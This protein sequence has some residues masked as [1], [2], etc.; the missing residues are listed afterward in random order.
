MPAGSHRFRT[1]TRRLLDIVVNSLYSHPDVFLRELV[2]NASDALDRLR[3]EALTDPGLAAGGSEPGIL[4]RPDAASGTL[5]VSDNGIGMTA[6]ELSRNLGTIAGSGTGR[7]LQG[8]DPAS[9][10]ELIGRFGVG[11]YSAFMVAGRVEV[12]SRRAGSDEPAARWESDGRDS[13][14]VEEAER[15]VGGT[16]VILHLK[17]GMEEYLDPERLGGIIRAYSDYLPHPVMLAMPDGSGGRAL[18]SGTPLWLTPGKDVR[19]GGYDDFYRRLSGS[20]DAP[21]SHLSCHVE[22]A[23][24]FHALLFIPSKRPFEAL[25]PDW[26]PGIDLYSRRI[27]ILQACP[28]ILPNWLRFVGGVVESPDLPLNISREMLQQSPALR[29][30]GRALTRKV[31]DWLARLAAGD[32]DGYASF[33]GEFGDFLKEGLLADAENRDETAGLL[34]AW[35]ASNPDRPL[36]LKGLPSD[37]P[38]GGNLY[39]VSGPD[40]K[41]LAA[42]PHLE[43]ARSAGAEVLLFDGPLDELIAP[44]LSSSLGR[45]LIALDREEADADLSDEE[46][47]RREE[48]SARLSGLL[49]FMKDVLGGAVGDVRVST[50]LDRSPCVVVPGMNDPGGAFRGMM[51]AMRREIAEVPGILEINPDHG[52][53]GYMMEL[54]ETSRSDGRLARCVRLVHQTGLILAGASPSDPAAFAGDV[55]AAI[56]EGR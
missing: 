6:D 23:V 1:E 27:R 10:P 21:F 49:E 13:F 12:V 48:A 56:L 46:R 18:N 2:S 43:A 28:D 55:C 33:F 42:S 44:V 15:T 24:E 38:G 16:D 14:T 32:G 11:F 30:I 47:R 31:L 35:T 54:F 45:R 25:M 4:I 50:R 34:M 41:A 9:A 22:G 51:K 3:F 17:D 53:T 20:P 40:R 36:L 37:G 8:A 5:T 7:F 26:H 52:L 29:T 19:E 39:Y